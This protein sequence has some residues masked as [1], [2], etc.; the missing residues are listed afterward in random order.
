MA[1]SWLLVYLTDSWKPGG[2]WQDRG[3]DP[4]LRTQPMT[5]G[6]CRTDVRR[7][8]AVGDDLFFV[9]CAPERPM[10][11]RYYLAAQFRVGEKIG[12]G[13][14]VQRFRGRPNV[15][16]DD[17]PFG[18]SLPERVRAYITAHRKD[19]RWP[20]RRAILASVDGDPDWA[21]DHAADFVAYVD[22]REYVHAYYD[23]HDDWRTR[24][25]DGPYLVADAVASK[26]LAEPISY[27]EL[28]ADCSDLPA[29]ERLRTIG[30]QPRHPR[31]LLRGLAAPLL[32][33]RVA[34]AGARPE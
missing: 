23:V 19:L 24:R 12:Q 9:A 11:D 33:D 5:W 31:R 10:L 7:Y 29:V 21:R 13:E 14:A 22:G 1:R 18:E 30:P 25:L 27:A 28:A 32:V 2:R 3:N 8:A 15:I 4:E 6:I 34:R 17:L 16:L 20:R 26:V